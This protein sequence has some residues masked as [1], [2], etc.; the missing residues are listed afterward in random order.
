MLTKTISSGNH[1]YPRNNIYPTSGNF[2]DVTSISLTAGNWLRCGVFGEGAATAGSGFYNDGM[3]IGVTTTTGN[4]SDWSNQRVDTLYSGATLPFNLDYF[5]RSIWTVPG[6]R[7][8]EINGTTTYYLK[9]NGPHIRGST[10]GSVPVDAYSGSKNS[11]K[12]NLGE[13]NKMMPH[14]TSQMPQHDDQDEDAEMIK[15][16]LQKIINEMD[17]LESNRIHPKV[18]A[19]K[20]DVTAPKDGMPS[21]DQPEDQMM[22]FGGAA[23]LKD[24]NGNHGETPEESEPE[25]Q[26][27]QHEGLDPDVLKKLLDRA[28]MADES[29]SESEDE[30]LDLPPAVADAVRKKR[31]PLPKS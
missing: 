18:M 14:D 31:Q 29:G 10:A 15:Q 30:F 9:Y 21:P 3:S 5:Y 4:S 26:F 13:Q 12:I 23:G 16:V 22:A 17:G 1:N 24:P 7:F 2:G 27:N 11:L 19:A 8:S 6:L 28:G 20:V 25:N